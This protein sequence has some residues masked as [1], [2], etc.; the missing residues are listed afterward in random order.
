MGTMK[1]RQ[2]EPKMKPG[3]TKTQITEEESCPGRKGVAV[4][5]ILL[6]RSGGKKQKG[7]QRRDEDHGLLG[8]WKTQKHIESKDPPGEKEHL[9]L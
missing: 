3:V 7:Q 9:K 2:S 1:V 6:P 8:I 4:G 5:E